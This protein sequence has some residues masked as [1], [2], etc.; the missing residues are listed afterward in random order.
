MLLT[1]F[2]G[3]RVRSVRVKLCAVM[4]MKQSDEA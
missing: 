4:D 3:E 1:A 2:N